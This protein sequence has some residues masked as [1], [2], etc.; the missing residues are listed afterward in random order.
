MKS[1]QTLFKVF[2]LLLLTANSGYCQTGTSGAPFTSL[3][4]AAA[5]TSAGIYYFNIGGNTFDTYVDANGFVQVAIDFGNGVGELPQ[6]TSLTTA[7][8]GVLNPTTLATLTETSIVRISSSTGNFDVTSTDATIISRVQSNTPLHRGLAD[9]AINDHWIGTN[10]VYITVNASGCTNSGTSLHQY[11]VHVCGNANGTHW[12]PFSNE[13]RE[14]YNALEIPDADFF[15]LW[16]RGDANLP[17]ELIKFEAKVTPSNEVKLFWQT[18]SELNNSGFEIHKSNN[19]KDWE[20]IDF[21]VGQGTTLE[22]S[23]YQYEDQKPLIGTNYYRL[24]QVDFDGAFE[25]S[26]TIAVEYNIE[27]SNITIFPNPSNGVVNLQINNPSNQKM[28]IKILDNLG[29]IIRDSEIIEGEANWQ[30]E[31][32]IKEKGIYTVAIQIGNEII[33]KRIVIA[34]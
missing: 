27:E 22:V 6:G 5:V 1:Q 7:T 11:I 15:Q 26:K 29:R 33:Y 12:N 10:A 13:Q 17:V 18:A 21:V 24:K 4:Q 3:H 16:V 2:M 23:N 14:R 8:R 34:D 19:G 30:Q 28:Q 9:N 20:T 32:V 25:Y 31:M